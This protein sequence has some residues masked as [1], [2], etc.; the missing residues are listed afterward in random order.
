M[1]GTFYKSEIPS[2][3]ILLDSLPDVY[4][5]VK[6]VMASDSSVLPKNLT[7][8]VG[9]MAYSVMDSINDVVTYAITSYTNDE[10]FDIN[11][12]SRIVN[13][14]VALD[15]NTRK[16]DVFFIE[17]YLYIHSNNTKIAPHISKIVLHSHTFQQ[18]DKYSYNLQSHKINWCEWVYPYTVGHPL[19]S[20]DKIFIKP[21]TINPAK[22]E[23]A[24]NEVLCRTIAAQ[25]DTKACSN[26]L[27]EETECLDG[28][29]FTAMTIS[30]L[31]D[32]YLKRS[33]KFGVMGITLNQSL[34]S[35]MNMDLPE[36]SDELYI[37][38]IKRVREEKRRRNK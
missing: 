24:D 34:G 14:V 16:M 36:P 35:F 11:Q 37:D 15:V 13:L 1:P 3:Y 21:N 19:D 7:G 30:N 31:S 17:Y 25:V 33:L 29:S 6:K 9:N 32:G 12:A 20:L 38:H 27:I 5:I 23:I 4:A 2:A 10:F 22:V 18:S 26:I 28:D 8:D